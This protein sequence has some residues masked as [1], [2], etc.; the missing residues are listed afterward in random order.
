MGPRPRALTPPGRSAAAAVLF[1]A[2]C[3]APTPVEP[4][5]GA[6]SAAAVLYRSGDLDVLVRPGDP[7]LQLPS[8][9]LSAVLFGR[10]EDLVGVPSGALGPTLERPCPLPEPTE[11]FELPT[12]EGP[13]SRLT[14]GPRVPRWYEGPPT[15]TQAL[16]VDTTCGEGNDDWRAAREGCAIRI[17]TTSPRLRNVRAGLGVTVAGF[18][19]LELLEP[20]AF[21]TD[22]VPMAPQPPALAT[23]MCRSGADSCHVDVFAPRPAARTASVS[24]GPPD[25]FELPPRVAP[26]PRFAYT[27]PAWSQG[28]L[29]VG[30][31][32][33]S[34]VRGLGC[35]SGAELRRLD[36]ATLTT[37]IADVA[38]PALECMSEVIPDQAGGV[39]VLGRRPE[40]GGRCPEVDEPERA[41]ALVHVDAR[42][43]VGA[44]EEL[45]A[46]CLPNAWRSEV[47][48]EG[49]VALGFGRRRVETTVRAEA[50]AL[51]LD[52][53][54]GRTSPV[55]DLTFVRPTAVPAEL[56]GLVSTS[57]GRWLALLR[58]PDQFV[59]L[60]LR[61]E[62]GRFELERDPIAPVPTIP[63]QPVAPRGF[64]YLPG[65][66]RIVAW[67]SA[68][69]KAAA[70]YWS[71]EPAA[72]GP[73]LAVSRTSRSPRDIFTGF[74]WSGTSEVPTFALLEMTQTETR[75]VELIITEVRS[76]EQRL[77]ALPRRTVLGRGTN[78][79]SVARDPA[80]R[81]F[82]TLPS[83]GALVRIEPDDP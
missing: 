16:A 18:T 54:D 73:A 40:L 5:P 69:P 80:G 31:G 9:P 79:P 52:V 21:A 53:R 22:C 83:A 48:A 37:T 25:D 8:G 76:A 62:G 50:R 47:D 67:T 30:V 28:R 51:V 56:A 19:A 7:E 27:G 64:T 20:T 42:G 29:W 39:W 70:L 13:W 72:S 24:L 14:S 2:A 65:A 63:V 81:V 59:E 11:R 32:R 38:V 41:W 61:A 34:A 10:A 15:T 75:S 26:P 23:A 74:P 57:A 71:P 77:R 43:R 35:A 44:T 36:P 3:I 45:G 49:R 78:H 6:E 4:P 33:P 60:E 68:D 12:S 55:L 66:D 1:G 58:G 17:D 82:V 46:P